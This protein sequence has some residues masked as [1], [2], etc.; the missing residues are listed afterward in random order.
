MIVNRIEGI[1]SSQVTQIWWRRD[2]CCVLIVGVALTRPAR[3]CLRFVKADKEIIVLKIVRD[4]RG[5]SED[6]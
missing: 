3:S 1:Y 4:I 5:V 6:C 2:C